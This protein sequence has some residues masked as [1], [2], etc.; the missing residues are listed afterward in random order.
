MTTPVSSEIFVFGSNLGGR[1]GLGAALDAKTLYGAIEG[2]LEGLQ[3]SSYGIPTKDLAMRSMSL[4]SINK[5]VYTFMEFAA[6]NPQLTFNVTPIG[7]GLAG[8]SHDDIGPLFAYAPTN[9]KIPLVWQKYMKQPNN[10]KYWN[11]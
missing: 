6:A 5:R 10:Y 1:H 9:C 11:C 2:Q 4:K 8:Y 7:T 3:G